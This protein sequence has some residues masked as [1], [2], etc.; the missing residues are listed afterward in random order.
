MTALDSTILSPARRF[1]F[2]VTAIRQIAGRA[3]LCLEW[4]RCDPIEEEA[5]H[6]M[7]LSVDS[8]DGVLVVTAAGFVSLSD[9]IS[10]FTKACDVAAQRGFHLI[11]VDCSSV[12][13]ELSTMER[14]ELGRTVAEYCSSRFMSPKVATVGNPPLI[15]GFAARVASN[16]GLAAETFSESQRAMGW[17]KGFSSKAAAHRIS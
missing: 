6:L 10:V 12:D 8:I 1:F 17:L 11:L 14:Y 15:D 4:P 7:N 3:T 9:A 13:G 2:L 16:R 5:M